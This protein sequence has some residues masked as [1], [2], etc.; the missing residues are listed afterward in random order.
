MNTEIMICSQKKSGSTE[1]KSLGGVSGIDKKL[2]IN[3]I[4]NILFI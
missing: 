4:I 3:L 1:V 2:Y